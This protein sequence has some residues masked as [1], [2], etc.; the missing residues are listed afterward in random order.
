M[1][2][3]DFWDNLKEKGSRFFNSAKDFV[4]D[5]KHLIYPLVK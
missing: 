2:L 3:D 4:K 1:A 5:N